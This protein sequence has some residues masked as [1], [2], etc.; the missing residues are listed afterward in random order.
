M[1]LQE[2]SRDVRGQI[3]AALESGGPPPV[4]EYDESRFLDG[5][6]KGQ[7][8]IGATRYEPDAAIF[9][10]IYP[11]PNGAPIVLA[12]RVRPP[13]RIVFLPVPE[14]V[15]ES[16]WQGEISGSYV[17]ESEAAAKLAE[18]TARLEPEANANEFGVRIAVGRQ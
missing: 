10:F 5:R 12:V 3:F 15:V 11:D 8:L 4:G 9:E 16:I 14:W 1:A 6:A 7:P 17:F 13:E 18:F 2:F